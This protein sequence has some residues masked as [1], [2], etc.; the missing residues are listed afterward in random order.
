MRNISRFLVP[1]LAALPACAALPSATGG[2][3]G[4]DYGAS[5]LNNDVYLYDS[6]NNSRQPE[7]NIRESNQE[8]S[9]AAGA[10]LGYQFASRKTRWF[11]ASRIQ[12]GVQIGY[13]DLGKA[14]NDV[15][16]FGSVDKAQENG[17]RKIEES[18]VDLLFVSTLRWENGFNLFFKGGAARLHGEYTQ[19]GLL[20]ARQPEF[21][22][23]KQTLTCNA[24]RP[25]LALGAGLMLC[26]HF[27]LQAQYAVILGS[28]PDKG[29]DRFKVEDMVQLPNNLYRAE[30][31]TV[32]ATLYF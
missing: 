22:P 23:S 19:E 24:I 16:Y 9:S 14:E 17:Y 25:E 28:T 29:T 21:V 1:L 6:G 10:F 4:L 2:Y 8:N 12:L 15:A 7:M 26:S 13:T 31:F 30:R 11:G 18:A 32:G 3:V 5:A 20:T 27:G